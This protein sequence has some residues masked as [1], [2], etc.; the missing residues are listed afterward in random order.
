[1][2]KERKREKS[3]RDKKKESGGSSPS[4]SAKEPYDEVGN[5]MAYESDEF[6]KADTIVLFQHLIDN[7]HAWTLQGHYGQTATRLI[8]EGLCHGSNPARDSKI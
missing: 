6:G 3:H 4:P 8:E 5:V 2:A 1:M 7:G